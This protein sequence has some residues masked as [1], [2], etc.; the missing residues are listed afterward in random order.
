MRIFD[1]PDWKIFSMKTPDDSTMTYDDSWW[2]KMTKEWPKMTP[3]WPKESKMIPGWPVDF[4]DRSSGWWV[5]FQRFY[6]GK[7]VALSLGH[8][9]ILEITK[10]ILTAILSILHR[11]RTLSAPGTQTFLP[12]R[13]WSDKLFQNHKGGKLIR[14]L[15]DKLLH[16]QQRN[17]RDGSYCILFIY[18]FESSGVRRYLYC[19]Y[20]LYFCVSHGLMINL[21]FYWP[22][23]NRNLIRR[24]DWLMLMPD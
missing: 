17:N 19:F 14:K 9:N 16:H 8:K 11:H 2:P 7:L 5:I 13:N 20:G 15:P 6:F 24:I 21:L 10:Y 1:C 22:I 23:Y 18:S 3:D 12:A 4:S